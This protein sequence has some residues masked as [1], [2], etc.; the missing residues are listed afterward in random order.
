MSYNRS[1]DKIDWV[2]FAD[3]PDLLPVN[4][5]LVFNQTKVIPARLILNRTS[6][7]KVSLLYLKTTADQLEVLANRSLKAGENLYHGDE[8][9]FTVRGKVSN[10]Y[11]LIPNFDLAKLAEILERFG[12]TPLPPYI[13]NSPL[14]EAQRREQYQTVFAS[15]AGSVAAPTASLHFTPELLQRLKTKGIQLEYLTLHVGLGTFAPLTPEQLQRGEL[16][17]EFFSISPETAE[18]L[19]EAKSSDRKIIAVGTTVARVLESDWNLAST[20]IFIRP[21]YQFKFVGGLITNFHV[22]RSSLLML[23]ATLVGREKLLTL[24]QKA[25][26]Q[27]FR[28]YSFGDGMLII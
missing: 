1:S 26:D 6:G 15:E 21:G 28:F 27:G 18:R 7:G 16:H 20:K 13:K 24:Y 23:V 2:T 4:S 3:L 9:L 25:I 12:V 11:Q 14:S 17:E 19:R 8:L 5:V 22:P 10:H